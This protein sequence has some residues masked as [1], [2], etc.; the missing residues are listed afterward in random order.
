MGRLKKA[1]I[2]IYLLLAA[3]P[4]VFI[5]VN[6]IRDN[7]I[8]SFQEFTDIISSDFQLLSSIIVISIIIIL[9]NLSLILAVILYPSTVN[10]II[11]KKDKGVLNISKKAIVGIVNANISNANILKDSNVNLKVIKH[12]IDVEVSGTS[13]TSVILTEA[14]ADLQSNIE[15]DLKQFINAPQEN[16]NINVNVNS[17]VGE[18]S[19][20]VI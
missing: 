8:N 6:F 4:S 16:I 14:V 1:T 17:V 12:K 7:Q 19:S 3:L 18:K 5:L 10:N 20:K 9:V 11:L 2:G 13:S 15:H